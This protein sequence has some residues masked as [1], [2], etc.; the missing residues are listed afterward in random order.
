MLAAAAACGSHPAQWGV[1]DGAVA[2][3]APGGATPDAALA[4]DADTR[5]VPSNGDA[6]GRLEPTGLTIG[7]SG[8]FDTSTECTRSSRLGVCAAASQP[9]GA[10]LCVCRA[11]DVTIA[12]LDVTGTRALVVLAWNQITVSGHLRLHADVDQDGPGA[13]RQYDVAATRSSGGAGGS[14]ATAGGAAGAAAP[15]GTASLEPLEGG[16]RGQDACNGTHGGGGGGAIQLTAGLR[17]RISGV[18]SAGGAGGGGGAGGTGA[19]AGGA[20]G[21]SGGGVLVEAPSVEVTGTIA[22]NGGGGGGGGSTSLGRPGEGGRAGTTPAAGGRGD[23]GGG[24]PFYGYTN[25]GWGGDG[26]T[27]TDPAQTGGPADSISG[28][29]DGTVYLGA[30]GG[31]GGVGRIRI[32][33]RSGCGCTGTFSPTPTSGRL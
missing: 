6:T 28:C 22:A 2:P 19:C 26:A 13:R 23:S 3:G 9:G 16:M 12:D 21:G 18:I 11:D 5:V 1:R 24:C 10:D 4:A 27:Q 32:N 33:T 25:G 30:G 29:I 15:W 8:A 17:V 31:G 14:F 20:G 7:I